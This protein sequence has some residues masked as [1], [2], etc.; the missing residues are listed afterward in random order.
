MSDGIGGDG[1]GRDRRRWVRVGLQL[2]GFAVGLS[3]LGWVVVLAAGE[4]DSAR[5][6]QLAGAPWWQVGLLVL[7][8]VLS[9]G[10]NGVAWWCAVRPARRVGF[11][12][13]M[14]TN[15]GATAL[16]LLPFKL[17]LLFRVV[18]HRRRDGVPVLVVGGWMGALAAMMGGALGPAVLATVVVGEVNGWWWLIALGGAGV[19]GVMIVLVARWVVSEVGGGFVAGLAGRLLGA[20]GRGFAGGEHYARLREGAVMLGDG[21][22]VAAGL[23][24]RLLDALGVGARFWLASRIAGEPIDAAAAL[25]AGT[26]FFVIGA[27]APTGAVGVREAGT[28]GLFAAMGVEQMAAAILLVSAVDAGVVLLLGLGGGAYVWPG[29]VR[30]RVES[31]RALG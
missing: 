1:V 10:V 21:R 15:A 19:C 28:A 16:A 13:V 29:V 7:L 8:S 17:S 20:R 11:S 24:L 6:E 12:S 31:G 3:L 5:R 4:L 22:A 9:V 26:G 23:S 27:V 2:L 25:I 30:G 18:S 14:A